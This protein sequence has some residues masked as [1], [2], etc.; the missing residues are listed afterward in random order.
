MI[1]ELRPDTGN[2]FSWSLPKP[3]GRNKHSS[4]RKGF[5]SEKQ[6]DP[7][8]SLYRHEIYRNPC[9][10]DD[11]I[12]G[13]CPACRS[14]RCWKEVPRRDTGIQ[15][16]ALGGGSNPF[17]VQAIPESSRPIRKA[18][19]KLFGSSSF[20]GLDYLF[21]KNRRYLWIGPK[22]NLNVRHFHRIYIRYGC[23]DEIR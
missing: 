1:S 23:D 10:S 3:S 22:Y 16:E 6:D 7:A 9:Q 13:V 20:G 8:E 2:I 5:F 12:P 15:G 14:Q 19:G 11:W 4:G 17:V 21:P 18:G